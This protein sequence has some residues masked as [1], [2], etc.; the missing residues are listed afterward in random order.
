[1]GPLAG[2]LGAVPLEAGRVLVRLATVATLVR[3]VE[4]ESVLPGHTACCLPDVAVGGDV[5]VEV[6]G[7]TERLV[8]VGTLVWGCVAVGGLVLLQM[9]F[10]PEPF[11][12]NLT[13]ERSLACKVT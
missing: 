9:R 11:V 13:L 2:V 10:L 4:K 1:M 8:A 7:V 5:G 3:S 12:A 6:G